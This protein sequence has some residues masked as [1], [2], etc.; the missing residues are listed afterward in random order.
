MGIMKFGN[1]ADPLEDILGEQPQTFKTI[2]GACP[3]SLDFVRQDWNDMQDT[4]AGMT[5]IIFDWDIP[6][7]DDTCKKLN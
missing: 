3:I 2:G 5:W 4:M 6:S 7:R 1:G